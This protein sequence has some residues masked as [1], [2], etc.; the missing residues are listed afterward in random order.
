MDFSA[1]VPVRP[2]ESIYV[3]RQGLGLGHIPTIGTARAVQHA[4]DQDDDGAVQ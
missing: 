4:S 1:K 3:G 2:K